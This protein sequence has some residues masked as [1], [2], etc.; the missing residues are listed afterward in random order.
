MIIGNSATQ[1]GVSEAT[2]GS[3]KHAVHCL[4]ARVNEAGVKQKICSLTIKSTV[5][6]FVTRTRSQL[7][8][9]L[10]YL[11]EAPFLIE[12]GCLRRF[13]LYLLQHTPS[14]LL[15]V[16]PFLCSWSMINKRAF[17]FWELRSQQRLR[18]DTIWEGGAF[19]LGIIWNNNNN[20]LQLHHRL[21]TYSTT[22]ITLISCCC[23]V[24]RL[25]LL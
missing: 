19:C 3:A 1:P 18:R 13:G 12:R 17:T 21:S 2:K 7:P 25:L 14:K 9:E 11:Q 20:H 5:M 10:Y 8:W 23:D 16:G 24:Q 6:F 22:G 4:Q 15:S